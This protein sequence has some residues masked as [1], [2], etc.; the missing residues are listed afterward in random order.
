MIATED[1]WLATQETLYLSSIPE[2]RESIVQARLEPLDEGSAE[3][4]W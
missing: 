1:D 2:V 3:L 4:P